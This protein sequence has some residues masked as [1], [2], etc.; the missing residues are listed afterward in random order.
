MR[1]IVVR[2][3]HELQNELSSV[4]SSKTDYR[5]L[6]EDT[7]SPE[8]AKEQWNMLWQVCGTEPENGQT[9][10]EIGSSFGAFVGYASKCGMSAFG[11]EPE[12][13]RV[14]IARD[15]LAAKGTKQILITTGVGECLP[16]LDAR[17]DVVYSTNVLEHVRNPEMV[18]AEGIRVLKPGGF[19]QFV[20][21][22]YGSWWEGHY[23][24]VW[25]PNMPRSLARLYVR[26]YGRHPTYLDT[27][28][29][30]NRRRLEQL[31]DKH[32]DRVE[33]LSWGEEIWEKRVRTIAFSE[34]AALGKLKN[35][36]Q[37]I[38]SLGLVEVVIWLGK[39]LHWETPLILTLRKIK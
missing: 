20:V 24:V 3:E 8:R 7:V 37:W 26:L 34:W 9:I 27:L 5:K 28:Q 30:I 13:E 38:H 2:T 21:P 17:F 39:R 4:V 10:L 18:I 19:L 35:I 11:I 33:I 14:H 29:F 1:N 36:V 12:R 25:L 15:L 31:L 32:R 22:N 23:G 16:F 6:A